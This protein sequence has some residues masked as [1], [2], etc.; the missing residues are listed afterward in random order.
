MQKTFEILKVHRQDVLKE[1]MKTL[2]FVL[3]PVPI[4]GKDHEK[5]KKCG[6]SYHSLFELQNMFR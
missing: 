4:Y 6:A 1:A 5:P 2:T 3:S